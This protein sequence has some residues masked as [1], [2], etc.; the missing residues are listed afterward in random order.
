MRELTPGT[1]S[2]IQEENSRETKTRELT[3]RKGRQCLGLVSQKLIHI[4]NLVSFSGQVMELARMS[5]TT[6]REGGF[7]RQRLGP[8]NP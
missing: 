7:K 6:T 2:S 3:E 5:M 8:W 4:A 1:P